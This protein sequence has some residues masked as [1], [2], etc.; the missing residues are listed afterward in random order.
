MIGIIATALALTIYRLMVSR[1]CTPRD[2]IT[3]QHFQ[4]CDITNGVDQKVLDSIPIQVYT[5]NQRAMRDGD[6]C[7]CAVCLGEFEEGDPVRIL[8]HCHHVFH[9][10]CIDEWIISH[11]ICP[12]CRFPIVAPTP[13]ESPVITDTNGQEAGHVPYLQSQTQGSLVISI[14]D[15]HVSGARRSSRVA[16]CR[17]SSFFSVERKPQIAFVQLKRSLSDCAHVS[18]EIDLEQEHELPSWLK[19]LKSIE[20][21]S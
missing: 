6:Q 13:P 14:D 10:Q 16:L 3:T 19:G 20:K 18:I 9:L 11:S 12:L 21:S 2:H 17:S 15:N 5:H 1:F 8:P 7:E 4:V